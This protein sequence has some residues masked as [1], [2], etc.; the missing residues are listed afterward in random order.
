MD[1]NWTFKP[2]LGGIM[3]DPPGVSAKDY[4]PSY[5]YVMSY[6]VF[7]D[8]RLIKDRDERIGAR[9]R[10]GTRLT[11]RISRIKALRLSPVTSLILLLSAT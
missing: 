10:A 3:R 6:T 5:M 7:H 1:E 4:T 8:A 11:N 2:G 9:T